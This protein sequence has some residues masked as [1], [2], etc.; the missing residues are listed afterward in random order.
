[1]STEREMKEKQEDRLYEIY[2]AQEMINAQLLD[3]YSL[4][5]NISSNK[6]KSGMTATEIDAVKQ[7]AID[8][9]KAYQKK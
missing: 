7:R 9:A 8:S 5:L 3:D 6:A 1:M 4:Y 2:F